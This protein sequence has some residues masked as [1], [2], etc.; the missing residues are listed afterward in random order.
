MKLKQLFESSN[1]IDINRFFADTHEYLEMCMNTNTD[2]IL[3]HGS[4]SLSNGEHKFLLRLGP[5][6]SGGDL[7]DAYNSWAKSKFGIEPRKWMFCVSHANGVRDYGK[8]HAV[9]PIGR[10]D[11]FKINGINDFY[12]DFGAVM[13]KYASHGKYPDE[14][15]ELTKMLDTHLEQGDIVFNENFYSVLKHSGE[16]VMIR[17]DRFY[18]FTID[19]MRYLLTQECDD[20]FAKYKTFLQKVLRD[21]QE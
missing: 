3:W 18:S 8:A 11:W 10:F 2:S 1:Q 7:F 6:D 17:C 16:E 19:S 13:R 15:A 4:Y 21:I 20:K 14:I 12:F 5:R 9:F